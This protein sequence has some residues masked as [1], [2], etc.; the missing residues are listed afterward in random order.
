MMAEGTVAVDG[1]NLMNIVKG[2][3]SKVAVEILTKRGLYGSRRSLPKVFCNKTSGG[4]LLIRKEFL[5]S[6]IKESCNVNEQQLKVIICDRIC[7]N[8]P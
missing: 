7:E 8:L 5:I 3:I 1:T 6:V 2:L 4:E